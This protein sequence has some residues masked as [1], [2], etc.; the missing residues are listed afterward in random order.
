MSG[1]RFSDS[2][3]QPN[4]GTVKVENLTRASGSERS[5]IQNGRNAAPRKS[6][7]AYTAL[8][9]AIQMGICTIIG[10]MPIIGDAPCSR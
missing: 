7:L 2:I 9:R 1:S 5:V 8:H 6:T 10:S 3:F 4:S